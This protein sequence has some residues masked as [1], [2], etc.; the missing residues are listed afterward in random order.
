[1]PEAF[2]QRDL[3]LGL[4][5]LNDRKNFILWIVLPRVLAFGT[6]MSCKWIVIEEKIKTKIDEISYPKKDSLI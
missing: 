2:A 5:L 3:F 4:M 6:F 1:M